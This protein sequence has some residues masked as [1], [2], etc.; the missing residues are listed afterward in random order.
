M[1]RKP[2]EEVLFHYMLSVAINELTFAFFMH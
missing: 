1:L 2:K